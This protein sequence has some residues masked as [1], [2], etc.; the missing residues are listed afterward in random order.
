MSFVT[1]KLQ[2]EILAREEADPPKPTVG[3]TDVFGAEFYPNLACAPIQ[4][5]SRSD[6]CVPQ[7]HPS[8]F[9]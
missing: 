6:S 3:G 8:F 1:A 7:A 4:A 9:P 5:E 2:F